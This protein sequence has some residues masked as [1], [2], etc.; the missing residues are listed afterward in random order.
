[1]LSCHG[2]TK[3]TVSNSSPGSFLPVEFFFPGIGDHEGQG[4]DPFVADVKWRVFTP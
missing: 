2:S 4:P 3:K 1:M